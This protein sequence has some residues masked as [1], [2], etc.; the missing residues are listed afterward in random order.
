MVRVTQHLM[1]SSVSRILLRLPINIILLIVVVLN[2]QMILVALHS[3]IGS[4]RSTTAARTLRAMSVMMV[5]RA[6]TTTTTAMGSRP[7]S[8]FEKVK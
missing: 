6:A 4:V 3:I 5:S 8:S 2:M 7:L 1:T